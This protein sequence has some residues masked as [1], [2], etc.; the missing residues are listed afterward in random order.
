[1][2]ILP[3]TFITTELIAPQ[4]LQ[5]GVVEAV[6]AEAMSAWERRAAAATGTTTRKRASEE[7]KD[8][9]ELLKGKDG[10]QMSQ[11]KS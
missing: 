6:V 4:D 11:N 5:V 2:T 3:S 7:R 10:Y 8:T 1:L 9:V